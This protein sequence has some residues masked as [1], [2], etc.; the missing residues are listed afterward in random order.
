MIRVR[1]S[2]FPIFVAMALFATSCGDSLPEPEPFGA[3]PTPEQVKWQRMEINMFCHFGPNTFSGREWGLGTEAEDLFAPTAMDCRQWVDV[4]A[5]A[6]M[7][8]IIITAKHH[9][10]FCLWPSKQSSHTVAQSR[11]QQGGGDVLRSLRQAIDAYN[12]SAPQHPLGM[13]V[14]VSPWDRNHPAYGTDGYNA[15]FAA[16]LEEVHSLYGPMFE[17]WFDGANGEGPNGKRQQYDWP[18]FNGT[19]SR[20][21]PGCVIFSDVGPGCRWVGNEEGH[22]DATNWS[23][24]AVGADERRTAQA[25]CG[26]PGGD[27][28]AP[29]EVDVSIRAGW[30][31]HQEEQ[32][33]SLDELMV[34]Y[35]N[36]VGRNGLLLLNVP[37]DNRGLIPAEDS[38]RL[39]EFR[40]E[41]DRIFG[42]DLA[43]GAIVS[44]SYYGDGRSQKYAPQNVID[45][46]YHTYWL[47]DSNATRAMLTLTFDSPRLFDVICLQ[48][49]ISLGQRVSR[50]RLEY[51]APGSNTWQ[52]LAEG[53]TIGY[54]RLLRLPTAVTASQ[55]RLCIDAALATPI[56]NRL[57]LHLASVPNCE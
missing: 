34:I 43:A 24:I 1:S 52:P 50:F 51:L 32:P 11:W 21:S 56:L 33:K 23:T 47:P 12:D 57:S 42:T 45:T 16:T 10:G 55:V 4:A 20:L 46:S 37:P 28:W 14:Y 7:G 26:V 53:T 17:Q 48:E 39:V 3:L 29:A 2:F 40:R 35:F 15:V 22:A 38:L 36:S 54:K 41:R 8:G 6:G 44:A 27:T 13:G 31:W 49:Y 19:A 18:L 5:Q 25:G 30:F 9:D